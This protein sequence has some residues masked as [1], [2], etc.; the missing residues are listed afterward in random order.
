MSLRLLSPDHGPQCS[1]GVGHV[2]PQ[3]AGT[4]FEILIVWQDQ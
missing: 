3:G 1:L 4:T 2:L